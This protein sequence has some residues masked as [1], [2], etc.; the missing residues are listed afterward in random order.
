MITN[1]VAPDKL[2]GLERYVRELSAELVR[3]KHR[4]T[5]ISKR[6]NDSQLATENFS[7]GVSVVRYDMPKKTDPFFALKYPL[8]T[9]FGVSRSLKKIKVQ[10][11]DSVVLHGHFPLPMLTMALLGTRYL[12]TCHAP[13]YKEILDERQASYALPKVLHQ[14]VVKS[15]KRVERFV[16]KRAVT[17]ITLSDFVAGEVVEIGAK[18]YDEVRRISGGLDTEWFTPGPRTALDGPEQERGGPRIFTARRLVK[19]TGVES[20]IRSM[21]G[22]LELEPGATLEIAGDGSLKKQL[23]ETVAELDLTNAVK[24]LGRI[25]EE[26]LLECYR[27][28]DIAV[29]PTRN[30]EGFGLATAEAMATGVVPLVTPVGANPE[31]VSKLSPN[32]VTSG[33][34]PEQLASGIVSL[35]RSPELASLRSRVRAA[36]HPEMGWPVVAE[37]YRRIYEAS[38]PSL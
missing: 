38:R 19:R 14:I 36:V 1:V 37:K 6:T 3:Q 8:A 28:A 26:E 16:M 17:V 29:T 4:V 25:S 9:A 13:V 31:L 24:F 10:S 20:L 23:E 12:Y 21:P 22:V 34:E 32:L 33:T 35:W 2:G 30:L 7:D 27:S 18:K 5:V 11:Q 15:F